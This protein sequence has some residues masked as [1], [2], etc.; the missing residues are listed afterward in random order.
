MEAEKE[1]SERFNISGKGNRP[2][3]KKIASKVV[4]QKFK[5]ENK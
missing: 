5:E 4:R 3:K 1:P 2:D